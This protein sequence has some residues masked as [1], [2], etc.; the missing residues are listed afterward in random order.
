[1]RWAKIWRAAWGLFLGAWLLA[2][3]AGT[4]GAA[5]TRMAFDV[6]G[7]KRSALIVERERLKKARRPLII[8][9]HGSKGSGVRLRRNL[10]LDD[11]IGG[12][13]GIVVYPDALEGT[14]SVVPGRPERPDDLGFIQAIV[15]RL[16]AEGRA[17]PR[18][19]YVVGVSTGGMMAMR[20]ACERADSFAGVAAMLANM[21]VE[22]AAA[23][24]PARAIAFLHING[25]ADP[26]VPYQGGALL[27]MDH[28]G[29]VLSTEATLAVFAGAGG[30]RGERKAVQ[31]PSRGPK[32]A[33]RAFFERYE[34]CKAPVEL[35]RVEGG[36][37]TIP[38]RW[39]GGGS[40]AGPHNTDVD[41]A[42]LTAEFFGRLSGE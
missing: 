38:G 25:T 36:G 27:K 11:V 5:A 19:V 28:A 17:D 31:A 21:P 14:W 7:V 32:G 26:R 39:S 41:A 20:L 34:S 4:A 37:H 3:S 22:L 15:T 24:K 33:S 40:Q 42:K 6:A 18:R 13:G 35:V 9:L 1:M 8:A 30:C 2:Q 29:D 16:V 12:G 10:Q 23:C